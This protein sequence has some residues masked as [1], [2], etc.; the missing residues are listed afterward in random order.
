[1]SEDLQ[2][3]NLLPVANQQDNVFSGSEGGSA[4]TPLLV[5]QSKKEVGT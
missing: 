5:Y 4:D 3:I 2:N 1:M